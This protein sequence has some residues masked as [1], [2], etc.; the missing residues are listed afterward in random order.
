MSEIKRV[1]AADVIRVGDR[2]RFSTELL[3][4]I[5][6]M[7]DHTSRVVRVE[8][9]DAFGGEVKVL[10]LQKVEGVMSGVDHAKALRRQARRVMGDESFLWVR[11]C[12][13]IL[14]R[15]FSSVA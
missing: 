2:I 3:K 8:R 12:S 5:D 13:R 14:S 4:D 9:I 10:L 15:G 7:L 6:G 11:R 1:E